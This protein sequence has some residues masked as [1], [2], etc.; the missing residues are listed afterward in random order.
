MRVAPAA[1][2]A[3]LPALLREKAPFLVVAAV[4][5]ATTYVTQTGAGADF[6]RVPPG[7]RAANAV[8]AI[9]RQLAGF[10]WPR[11]LAV[12]YPYPA[13]WPWGAVAGAIGHGSWSAGCGSSACWSRRSASCRQACSRRPIVSRTCRS[14]VSR[15][16]S[17]RGRRHARSRGPACGSSRA[18]APR[19]VRWA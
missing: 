3:S 12:I 19:P 9:V 6:L 2:R 14:S 1:L 5:A 4:A 17:W 16:R 8:V 18:R 13:G 7:V 15:S 10:V 11:G